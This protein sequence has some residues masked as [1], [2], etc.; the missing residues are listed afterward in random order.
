[1]P[2]V[3]WLIQVDKGTYS[4]REGALCIALAPRPR[5]EWYR[6]DLTENKPLLARCDYFQLVRVGARARAS[7]SSGFLRQPERLTGSP[8]RPEGH[9]GR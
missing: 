2:F 8:P 1:M 6:T 9:R 5:P 7:Q 3:F 4:T